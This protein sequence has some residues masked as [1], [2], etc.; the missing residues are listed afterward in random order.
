MLNSNH[1][2][3]CWNFDGDKKSWMALVLWLSS[4]YYRVIGFVLANFVIKK[5]ST[6][7]GR[8]FKSLTH[9][10]RHK[11]R[12]VLIP[13]FWILNNF[14]RLKWKCM[15]VF[16]EIQQNSRKSCQSSKKKSFKRTLNKQ[17]VTLDV[18]KEYNWLKKS[19]I[20]DIF[21]KKFVKSVKSTV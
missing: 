17:N 2:F 14:W 11:W 12:F 5:E 13:N 8:F 15:L 1:F 6:V 20:S 21:C 19:S 10:F 3:F 18:V 16:Q 9:F 7:L 4:I